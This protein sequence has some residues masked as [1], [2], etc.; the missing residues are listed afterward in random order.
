MIWRCVAG[1]WYEMFWLIWNWCH[2]G[3]DTRTDLTSVKIGSITWIC[4]QNLPLPKMSIR[5][6]SRHND[7]N[8]LIVTGR[9]A[10]YVVYSREMPSSLI[11]S[12]VV[13]AGN[14]T[15]TCESGVYTY[16]TREFVNTRKLIRST[17]YLHLHLT[18]TNW[19]YLSNIENIS[20]PS[21]FSCWICACN[22]WLELY[23]GKIWND[24]WLE[25]KISSRLSSHQILC[26][27]Q[28]HDQ[29]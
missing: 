2:Y 10:E 25:R 6:L 17:H 24:S 26:F 23:V 9:V 8:L 22:L 28:P 5:L 12:A 13:L 19:C 20:G 11:Y 14:L 18:H 16:H 4:K 3:T 21:L 1:L 15:V 7:W 27:T 29:R